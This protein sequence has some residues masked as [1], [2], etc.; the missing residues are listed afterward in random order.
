MTDFIPDIVLDSYSMGLKKDKARE[1]TSFF[2]NYYSKSVILSWYKKND[3]EVFTSQMDNVDDGNLLHSTVDYN[4]RQRKDEKFF[5]LDPLVF[6]DILNHSNSDI[7]KEDMKFIY[8]K[9]VKFK[10]KKI[11]YR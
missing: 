4:S 7:S 11:Y 6:K 2:I 8:N 5:L 3:M 10:D 1:I 9:L